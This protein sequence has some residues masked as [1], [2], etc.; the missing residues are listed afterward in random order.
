MYVCM[1]VCIYRISNHIVIFPLPRCFFV[2][3]PP[4]V[5]TNP[6]GCSSLHQTMQWLLRC[7]SQEAQVL[8]ITHIVLYIDT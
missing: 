6:H 3:T 4:R 7:A 2:E 1:Y 8:K 5:E